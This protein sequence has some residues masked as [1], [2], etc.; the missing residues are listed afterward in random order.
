[1]M[2]GEPALMFFQHVTGFVPVAGSIQP[3]AAAPNEI[4][5]SLLEIINVYQRGI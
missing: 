5:R 1:M 3:S 4:I 2:G